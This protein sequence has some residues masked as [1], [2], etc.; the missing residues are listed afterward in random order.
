[1][2][3]LEADGL[4]RRTQYR[5]GIRGYTGPAGSVLRIATFDERLE[6]DRLA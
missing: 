2:K 4:Y 1:M 6:L 5:G 3:A